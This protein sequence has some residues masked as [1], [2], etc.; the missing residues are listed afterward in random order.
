MRLHGNSLYNSNLHHLYEIRDKKENDIF[1]YGI[2][3]DPIEEDG[4]SKRLRI[5]INYLNL[6]VNEERFEGEVLITNIKGRKKAKELENLY[7]DTYRS[8]NGRNP[9]GNPP[10]G[11][12]PK[13]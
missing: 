6:V 10:L 1:K 4:L 11:R 2:S 13:K 3:D 7:I 8:K 9:R 5:Q 12:K